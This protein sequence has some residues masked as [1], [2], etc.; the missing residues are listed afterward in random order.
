MV[1][2]FVLS[3][4]EKLF[5]ILLVELASQNDK[6]K[7]RNIIIPIKVVICFVPLIRLTDITKSTT[8][9]K[10]N[11]TLIAEKTPIDIRQQAIT[12][13]IKN[14]SKNITKIEKYTDF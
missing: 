5:F 6:I 3:I 13:T 8:N 1:T 9:K 2:V 14:V 12:I 7:S 4:V 11:T 10:T